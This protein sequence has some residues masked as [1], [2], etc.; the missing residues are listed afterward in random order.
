M[1]AIP[2]HLARKFQLNCWTVFERNVTESLKIANDVIE[3]GLQLGNRDD[4]DG[5]LREMQ[6]NDMSIELI[7]RIFIDLIIAAGDTTA[8]TTQWT[9]YLLTQNRIVQQEIRQEIYDA[10]QS[11]RAQY[12]TALVKG[13]VRESMRLYPV[14]T[15][16]GRILDTDAVLNN[17]AV[18]K[19]SLV[20]I[21]M[22]SAGRDE[23]SFPDA[24]RFMPSRWTRN[25]ASGQLV[26][27]NRPQSS[28]PYALGAR[29]CIGQ[30][31]ANIQM[32]TILAKI[33]KNFELKLMNEREIK[34]IM[35]L[36]VVPSEKVKLGIRKL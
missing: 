5:L 32:H 33:L 17:F 2:P 25:P 3:Y 18:S 15:F 34:A 14:A 9:L 21:S 29:N 27:V 1:A 28:L 7:K 30:K 19:H 4:R 23:I 8:F 36:V 26:C 22:Y 12:E 13:S 35:R 11:Q 10:T 6:A 24:S 16:V 31:I 20:L